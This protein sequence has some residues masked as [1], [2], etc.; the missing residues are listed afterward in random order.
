MTRRVAFVGP[1]PPPVH[2]FA[3]VCAQMLGLLKAGSDVEVFDRAPRTTN[4]TANILKQLLRPC[5]FFA[6]SL[7]HHEVSLYLALSGGLGQI[8]DWLYLLVCKIFRHRIF[9]HHHSFSYVNAPSLLNQL[10]FSIVRHETHIVLSRGMGLAL[11][12]AYNIDATKVRVM[13][14]AA[15]FPPKPHVAPNRLNESTPIRLGFISNITFEKGFVEF[16]AVLSELKK[17][18]VPYRAQIAGPV[19]PAAREAFAEL[20]ASSVDTIH[21]GPIYGETKDRFYQQ[22]DVLLFPTKY[23]N[24][25]EPLVIHEALRNGVH[26]IACDRG[27]I[28]ELLK[29]GAGSIFTNDDFV[30]AAV[31]RLQTL[32]ADSAAL[33]L[34]RQSSFAESQRINHDARA[35]LTALLTE[36]AGNNAPSV[37]SDKARDKCD[38][39]SV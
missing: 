34:A 18:G 4:K 27:A 33:N 32:S 35:A 20:L 23:S 2:G 38:S 22:L 12:R 30:G 26:V 13:S 7:A 1:L 28:A 15:F 24:E 9:I 37:D 36:I 5:R 8:Y 3:N 10:F 11:A 21:L 17:L 19:A 29:N 14:N 25:A 6:L 39:E 31:T 16:F